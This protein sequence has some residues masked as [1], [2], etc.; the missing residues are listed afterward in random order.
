MRFFL[1]TASVTDIAWGATTGLIDGVATHPTQVAA[2]EP[3]RDYHEQITEIA[4][5]VR[6][7]VFASVA[8]VD[9]DEMYEDGR[10]LAKLADNVV[11]NVPMIEEGIVATRRLAAEGVRV[12]TTLVFSA[13]QAI[14][15]ARAGAAFVSTSIAELD[16]IGGDGLATV[17]DIREVFDNFALESEIVASSIRDPAQAISAARIGADAV[18]LPPSV[19]RALLVHPLTDRGLDQFLNEWSKRLAKSR[20]GA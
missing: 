20:A 2:H 5:L 12:N 10:E 1:D 6:G 8:P 16:D 11:V 13:A 3:E 15:A 19:L 14:F 4:R 18:A 7:P 9:A 17:R